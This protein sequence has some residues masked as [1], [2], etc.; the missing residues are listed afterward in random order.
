MGAD[1]R[2][3][4]KDNIAQLF[5]RVVGDA[6]YY[7]AVCFDAQPFVLLGEFECVHAC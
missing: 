7:A 1:V 3:F 5:L 4:D 6:E 2:Q